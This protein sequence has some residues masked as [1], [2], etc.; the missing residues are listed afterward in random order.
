[1]IE[2]MNHHGYWLQALIYQTALHRHL[3][4]R[5]KNYDMDKNLAPV[6]Y[7]FLRGV[8]KNTNYGH[9]KIEIPNEIVKEFD[10]II[11]GVRS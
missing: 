9:L 5:L 1:M 6:E 7:F 4:N 11:Q 2:A 8:K 10:E 3:K